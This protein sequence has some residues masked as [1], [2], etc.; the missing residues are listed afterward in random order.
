MSRPTRRCHSLRRAVISVLALGALTACATVPVTGRSQMI[1]VPTAI[2]HSLSFS[3][4]ADVLKTGKPLPATD[5][6]AEAVSRVGVRVQRAVEGYMKA[7]GLESELK[8][9]QWAFTTLDEN[10]VNAWCMPG[11][12]VAVYTGILPVTQS[13]AGLAVVM[14]HE[15][16]HAIA[17]HGGERMSQALVLGLGGLAIDQ[18]L[19]EKSRETRALF[20]GL[21]TVGSAVALELPHSRMQE[22]EADKLGLIFMSLAGYDPQEAVPFW[23]RMA[24]ASGGKGPPEFLSTHPSNATRIRQLSALILEI[25]QQY[26]QPR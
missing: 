24:A 11:G 7:N 10:E 25:R 15:I 26:Y 13:E 4:Y 18:A 8:D 23:E 17:R 3:Q 16:A 22:S 19:K 2:M 1:L 9:Y 21:Y 14:G 5:R 6:R 12:K 20:A